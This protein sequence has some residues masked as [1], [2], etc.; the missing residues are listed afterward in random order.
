MKFSGFQV[1]KTSAN[2]R[3]LL[4]LLPFA[5]DVR[6]P[7]AQV[8]GAKVVNYFGLSKNEPIKNATYAN[9]A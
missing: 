9:F 5:N 8:H 4:C 7:S 3:L 2:K 6:H 1:T